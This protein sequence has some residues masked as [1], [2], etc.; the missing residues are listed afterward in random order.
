MQLE[1]SVVLGT[2]LFLQFGQYGSI[3]STCGFGFLFV[4]RCS[5]PFSARNDSNFFKTSWCPLLV[6]SIYGTP[7]QA[8]IDL[9]LAMIFV[10]V[11]DFTIT[12]SQYLL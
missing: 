4:V 10:L 2:N 3:S 11:V 9:R 1:T 8:K 5:I 7:N 12:T 6:F